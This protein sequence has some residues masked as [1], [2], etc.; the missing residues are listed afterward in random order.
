MISSLR[1]LEQQIPSPKPIK[2]KRT[3]KAAPPVPTPVTAAELRGDVPEPQA[4]AKTS[5][6]WP[7][8]GLVLIVLA[9]AGVFAKLRSAKS[10]PG[11]SKESLA[12]ILAD[13]PEPIT[14]AELPHHQPK[15][16]SPNVALDDDVLTALVF[17]QLPIVE[18]TPE[19]APPA[20]KPASRKIFRLDPPEE[21]AQAA[22]KKPYIHARPQSNPAQDKPVP[23]E[24]KAKKPQEA[25]GLL[26]RVLQRANERRAA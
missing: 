3:V 21:E 15:T 6:W 7:Y 9:A 25:L 2:T 14:V 26:D 19:P 10:S 13:K 20:E 1:K 5:S 18:E 11:I 22:V 16:I 8:L 24:P 12:A 17:N 23:S 4:T